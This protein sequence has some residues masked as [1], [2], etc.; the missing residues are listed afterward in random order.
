MNR[1]VSFTQGIWRELAMAQRHVATR[2]L[3]RY[4]VDIVLYRYM[5]VRVPKRLDARRTI[6]LKNGVRVVY[7]LNRGD[8][9]TV[10]EVWFQETYRLPYELPGDRG[11]LLDLGA[12]IGLTSVYLARRHGFERIVAVEPLADNAALARCNLA[13]NHISAEVVEAAI[14]PQAGHATFAPADDHNAGRVTADGSGLPVSLVTVDE[15]APEPIR[16]VKLDIEGAE[17][18]LLTA[19]N[20]WLGRT[21]GLIVEFHPAMIDYPELAHQVRDQHAFTFY[22]PG[23]VHRYTT[24]GYL[25]SRCLQ[26]PR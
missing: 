5:R 20:E 17:A 16:L 2:S 24:D 11:T 7:R 15:I 12:N 4:A 1:L 8:I 14:A 25:A 3:P 10:R 23:S 19:N 21:T 22:P 6:A 9:Q 13:M 18:A 26:P